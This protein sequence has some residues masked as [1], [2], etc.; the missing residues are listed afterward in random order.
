VFKSTTV[1]AAHSRSQQETQH[2]INHLLF[3]YQNELAKVK[4]DSFV[5]LARTQDEQ[6]AAERELQHDKRILKQRKKEQELAHIELLHN[7]RLVW[8]FFRLT[9]NDHSLLCTNFGTFT[10]FMVTGTRAPND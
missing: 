6:R 10:L 7:L 3:E 9:H 5:T 2:K 1:V 4:T 8:H